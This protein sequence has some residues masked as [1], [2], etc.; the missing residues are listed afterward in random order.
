MAFPI[1]ENTRKALEKIEKEPQLILKIDGLNEIFGCVIVEVPARYDE[2]DLYYDQPSLYYDG[3][4]PS[5][6]GRDWINAQKSSNSISQQ[7]EPDKASNSSTS[8]MT[9]EILDVN[10]RMSEI[11]S[12]DFG[13]DEILGRRAKAYMMLRGTGFPLDAITL[14]YGIIEEVV[15]IPTA[16]RITVS[17]PQN[18]LRQEI[19]EKWDAKLTKYCHYRSCDVDEKLLILNRDIDGAY[20]TL[21]FFDAGSGNPISFIVAGNTINIYADP[22]NHTWDNVASEINRHAQAALLVEAKSLVNE[23]FYVAAS[24]TTFDSNYIEVDNLDYIIEENADPTFSNYFIIDQEV[25]KIDS[26]DYNLKRIYF[27]LRSRFETALPK[28]FEPDTDVSSFYVIEGNAIEL[29]LKLM[30]S[31]SNE[32]YEAECTSYG[33]VLDVGYVQNAI[34]FYRKN[35]KE[36]F[37]LVVGDKISVDT[38]FTDRTIVSFGF[39]YDSSYIVV[40]GPDIGSNLSTSLNTTFKSKY[41]VMPV[42]AGLNSIHIDVQQYVDI[43]SFYFSFIPNMRF[44][45]KEPI[46]LKEFLEE[47]IYFVSSLYSAPR[48]GRISIA[49]TKPSTIG[50][51]TKVLD[52]TNV[53]NPESNSIARSLNYNY[54]NGIEWIYDQDAI[55]DEGVTTNLTVSTQSIDRFKVGRRTLKIDASG[56][57]TDLDAETF[58]RYNSRRILDRYKFAAESLTLKTTLGAGLDLEIADTVIFG[59]PNF[60][61]T[62]IT[63]GNRN[64]VQRIFEI[65]N[66]TQYMDKCEFQLLETK[67]KADGRYGGFSPSSKIAQ[68]ISLTELNLESIGTLT[69]FTE[70]SKWKPYFGQTIAI[71]S[72]DWTYYEEC[73]LVGFADYND[74]KAIIEGLTILPSVGFIVDAP[75]YNN[76]AD[77]ITFAFWKGSHC[78]SNPQIQI[79]GSVSNIEF[80]LSPTDIAKLTVG[81]PVRVH[82]DSYSNDSGVDDY[83]IAEIIGNN[84]KLNQI[85]SFV[86]AI[87]NKM[88]LNGFKDK[89]RPYRYI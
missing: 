34:F 65:V 73:K 33:Y 75:K 84:V 1:T 23:P 4:A 70:K 80:T 31:K 47:K 24:K 57:R 76:D 46:Q 7:V 89:G 77:F 30:L 68:V 49:I 25:I 82:N 60:S 43:L 18:I 66:K 42:G 35:V 83:S 87:G 71:R 15:S 45:I 13:L 16:V 79:T 50:N 12:P 55:T 8:T 6:D 78:F 19:I 64:F 85:L 40:S 74:T 10:G 17:A 59:D 67:Y 20:I 69:S 44:F 36:D 72:L 81:Q 58:I 14:M 11:I 5:K 39:T 26:I 27:S 62:D 51:E 9:F 88:D 63:T 54:Y 2:D 86:P 3:F 37:S 32:I 41:D 48:K 22:I 52:P 21:N 61:L 28:E 53:L 38:L 29:A 56:L